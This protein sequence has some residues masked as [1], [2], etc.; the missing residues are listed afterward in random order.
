MLVVVALVLG[1]GIGRSLQPDPGTAAARALERD[2]L[3]VVL[4]ADAV[5]L[6]PTA[7]GVA[8]SAAIAAL[9]AGDPEPVAAG[10]TAWLA[11]YDTVLVRLVGV[12]LPDPA[13]PIQRQ[14]IAGVTLSRDAV[15]L[16]QRAAEVPPGRHRAD[17][18]DEAVRLRLRSEQLVLS[19]RASVADLDGARRRIALLPTLPGLGSGEA[20]S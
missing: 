6:G 19:A 1:A 8:V 12:E 17:L 14:F 7:D 10:A 13:R 11:A 2:V 5:W 9:R 15:E 18:L 4:D 16:V 20:G 3:P